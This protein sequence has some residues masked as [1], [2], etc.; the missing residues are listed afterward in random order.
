MFKALFLML[1]PQQW[2][3]NFFV[4]SALIFSQHLFILPSLYLTWIIFIIFCLA[5]SG[6]YI[7]NDLM[8]LKQ[9]QL[10]PE[11][12]LRPIAAGKIKPRLAI[13]ILIGLI[14]IALGWAYYTALSFGL[15]I[16]FYL[17]LNLGYSL[18][19]KHIPILDVIL[20]SIGFLLRIIAGALIINV[21]ISHW[22]IL[23]GFLLALFLSFSKR[24]NELQRLKTKAIEHRESLRG[25]TLNFLDQI[26]TIITAAT[27][28]VYLLYTVSPEV[29]QKI[30][31]NYLIYSGLFVLFGLLRYLSL[32]REGEAK[33]YLK[34]IFQDKKLLIN[35]L[36]WISSICIIFYCL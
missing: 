5:A 3:K 36:L 26:L 22:I 35:N 28:V 25:Y 9:D 6:V 19:L 4:F 21:S 12:C 32:I 18:G 1:R 2:V 7:F 30:G 34:I 33:D 31:N 27:L 11:K 13:I 17:L 23:A 16:T 20:V 24:R 15:I 14:I 10:H 8:D 29:T